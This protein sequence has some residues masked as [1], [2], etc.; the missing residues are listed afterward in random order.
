[1]RTER[2]PL[3][4]QGP[5][6]V[7]VLWVALKTTLALKC[8]GQGLVNV[9]FVKRKSL[10]AL[11]DYLSALALSLSALSQTLQ[12]SPGRRVLTQWAGVGEA[13]NCSP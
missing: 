8:Q 2:E 7:N 12:R 6:L 11:S 1:M 4:G 9:L 5:G 10:S 3:K 13:A